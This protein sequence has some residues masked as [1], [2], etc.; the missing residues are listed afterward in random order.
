MLPSTSAAD[1]LIHFLLDDV[2]VVK[3]ESVQ[4]EFWYPELV[5]R[6]HYIPYRSDSSNLVQVLENATS[7]I[8]L[9]EEISQQATD[10]ALSRLGANRVMCYWVSLIYEY[11]EM[12]KP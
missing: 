8:T 11:A 12:Y 6:K 1:R 7:N 10:F 4:Q 3:Q 2:V 5:P 9:L